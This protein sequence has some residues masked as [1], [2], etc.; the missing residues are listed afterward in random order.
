MTREGV[1]I[2]QRAQYSTSTEGDNSTENLLNIDPD[3]N[4]K[5]VSKLCL[6]LAI[7]V[8]CV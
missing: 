7:H 4:S 1:K 6:T 2:Q 5:E 8:V 3:R